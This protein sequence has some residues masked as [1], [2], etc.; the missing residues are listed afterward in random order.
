MDAAAVDIIC[1]ACDSVSGLRPGAASVCPLCQCPFAPPDVTEAEVGDPADRRI[2]VRTQLSADQQRL[3]TSLR[4]AYEH[5]SDALSHAGPPLLHP[6]H[7]DPA[8]PVG[9]RMGDYEI[10]GVLGRGGMGIVYRAQ[11]LSLGREVALKLL[12]GRA[13]RSD[14]AVKRFLAEAQA[15]ARVHHTNVVPVF[16]QGEY[17]GQCYYVMELIEGVSLDEL[18]R[19][20]SR[21][22]TSIDFRKTAAMFADVADGLASAHRLGII[23]RDVK[24][25]NLLLDTHGALHLTDFGLARFTEA[26]HLTLSGEL[27]GTPAYLSPEQVQSDAGA[28]VDGRT[29]VYSLGATLYE[30]LTRRKPFVAAGRH[31][32]LHA[33]CTADLAPPRRLNPQ[34]PRDLETICLRAMERE[35]N[36]RH[37]SAEVF[38]E[39]LRRFARGRPILTPRA[40]PV[41]RAGRWVRRHRWLSTVGVFI[42]LIALS[43]TAW[44]WSAAASRRREARYLLETAYTQLAYLDYHEHDAVQDDIARAASLG[45]DPDELHIVQA[46]AR[47]GA[48]EQ[49]DAIAHL[50]AV[51]AHDPSNPRAGYLLAWAQW[52]RGDHDAALATIKSLGQRRL[53]EAPDVWFFRGLALHF[54]DPSAAITSYREAIRLRAQE[55]GFYPLAVLHLARGRNQQMYATRSLAPFADVQSSLGQLVEHGYY[56]AYPYYLL[57]IAHRLAAEIYDGSRGTRDA[58]L[59][60]EHFDQALDWARRGQQ[61]DPTSDRCIVAEAECL[62]SMN[63]FEEAI[64][65]RTRAIS[66]AT[67]AS[68]VCESYHYRW[69]LRYWTGDLEGAFDDVERHSACVPENRCYRHVYPALILAEQG[70]LDAALDHARALADDAPTCAPAV[71]WSAACLRLLGKEDEAAEALRA[72]ADLVNFSAELEPPQTETWLRALYAFC[73][74][75]EDRETLDALAAEADQP[76]KLWGESAFHAGVMHLADGDRTAA[77][78]AFEQAYRSFDGELRYTFHAKVLRNMLRSDSAW[79]WWI[80]AQEACPVSPATELNVASPKH[81]VETD[82]EGD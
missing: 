50:E 29:D 15:A 14:A 19:T 38:A 43:V 56:R 45:A 24:P 22:A 41:V 81:S 80:P 35:P 10:R 61:V 42:L 78:A 47:L 17:E 62:E 12:P 59:V 64:E 44:A 54:A 77:L 39:D 23:H 55:S 40:G 8:L 69:R 7:G 48:G 9:T 27:L 60:E 28:V 5:F 65:A 82:P 6:G 79:P 57:S 34:V 74:R 36:R 11:Q 67:G 72:H 52:R 58:S 26:P 46:L 71:L 68:A 49:E 73:Q 4:R 25:H 3:M 32:L 16:A 75:S 66:I 2:P 30:W 53:P 31:Q 37:P 20:E 33:I 1:P 51:L 70:D 76:W 21:Q 18:L 13:H 63:R